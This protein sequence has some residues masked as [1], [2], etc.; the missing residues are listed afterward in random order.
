MHSQLIPPTRI[1]SKGKL[2]LELL[3]GCLHFMGFVKCLACIK[4]VEQTCYS[5][6]N[7]R[8]T[9]EIQWI[10]I[11]LQVTFQ[12]SKFMI[13]SH[14]VFSILLLLNDPLCSFHTLSTWIGI[15]RFI[16]IITRVLKY[17]RFVELVYWNHL[18]SLKSFN[19]NI[20]RIT[21]GDLYWAHV[22]RS[23]VMHLIWSTKPQHFNG[24]CNTWHLTLIGW[25]LWSSVSP[26][27]TCELTDLTTHG[28]QA[29]SCDSLII[30]ASPQA[31]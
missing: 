3:F 4:W 23:L 10:F 26:M 17:D 16:T 8:L 1:C 15:Y 30:P 18:F 12:V 22:N 7:T 31:I 19:L 28:L 25:M 21:N 29:Q 24:I 5:L 13:E 11:I 20:L 2:F 6:A 27:Y 14:F 9:C